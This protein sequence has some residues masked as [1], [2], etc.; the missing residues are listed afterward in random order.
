MAQFKTTML[1]SSVAGFAS[2]QPGQWVQIETG[3]RGQYLGTTATGSAVVRWQQGD[4]KFAR[5]DAVNNKHLRNFAKV[6][7]SK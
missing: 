6:Y 7:G 3:S 2:I 1:V 4:V 5:K